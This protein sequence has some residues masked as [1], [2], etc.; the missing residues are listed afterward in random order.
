MDTVKPE[1]WLSALQILTTSPRLSRKILPSPKNNSFRAQ[2]SY[3]ESDNLNILG[4]YLRNPS[5]I[6]GAND[7]SATI[8]MP[9]EGT[10]DFQ[11]MD[12]HCLCGPW[13]P[14]LL[15]ADEDFHATLSED[16]HLLIVQL[17]FPEGTDYQ[18]TAF[19]R[20]Q[21]ALSDLFAAFLYQTPF[22]RDYE[23]AKSRLKDLSVQLYDIIDG[24]GSLPDDLQSQKK[25]RDERRLCNAVRLLNTELETD[26][27][28]E[29]IASRSGL[30]LRNFHYL[31]KQY[32]GQSPYQYLRGRR[33]IK[34]REAII[35]NY[36]EKI[37]IA[38]QAL[39]LGFQHAGRF[40]AYYHKHFGEYPN[41]TLSKLDHLKQ[42]TDRV[43]SIGDETG[44]ISQ[45]W[46]TSATAPE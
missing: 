38:Q 26:I 32:I 34:V 1:N 22:F 5:L 14:F 19:Q 18:R 2:L 45:Y 33:L 39:N 25:V 20:Q 37:S 46:L 41:E 16:T 9:V 30:S 44:H 35:R 3:L 12:D 15:E 28:L 6:S 36:P 40:S 29:S 13:T 24:G 27:N 10:V 17:R 42:M 11:V 4:G 8:V 31:M 7:G 21:A 43:K 23:H